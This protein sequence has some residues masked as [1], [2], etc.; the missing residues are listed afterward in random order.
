MGD[1]VNRDL[2]NLKIETHTHESDNWS[3]LH[4]KYYAVDDTPEYETLATKVAFKLQA[5]TDKFIQ[6]S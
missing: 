2:I 1:Q 3:C 6:M 5:A 4:V